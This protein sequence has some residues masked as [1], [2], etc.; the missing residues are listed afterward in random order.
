MSRIRMRKPVGAPSLPGSSL[1]EYWVLAM[2]MGVSP[3]PSA[4]SCSS[5]RSAAAAKR[6][7]EHTSELQ[8][9]SDLVCRLL[10]E[11]KKKITQ[12]E[13]ASQKL[14]G[15]YPNK[16]NVSSDQHT[17]HAD[18]VQRRRRTSTIGSHREQ[19]RV[20]DVKDSS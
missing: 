19:L 20:M 18:I 12:K 5:A 3:S 2:Q 1:K 4:G 13:T 15:D 16:D 14:I 8:S 11:K 6:S 9:R 10:L 7:E 17:R